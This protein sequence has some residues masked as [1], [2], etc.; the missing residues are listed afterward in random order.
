VQLDPVL[1]RVEIVGGAGSGHVLSFSAADPARLP[2]PSSLC[3]SL[4]AGSVQN[5]QQY[6]SRLR[7]QLAATKRAQ[8]TLK[9]AQRQVER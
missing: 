4:V 5:A 2:A 7:Q 1:D 8:A 6:T 3:A 9:L